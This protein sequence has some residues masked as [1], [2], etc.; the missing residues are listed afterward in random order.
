MITNFFLENKDLQIT[1]DEKLMQSALAIQ[2]FMS[3][4]PNDKELKNVQENID[5]LATLQY[6]FALHKNDSTPIHSPHTS[7]EFLVLNANGE[8]LL[9]SARPLPAPFINEPAGLSLANYQHKSW[10]IFTTIDPTSKIKIIVAEQYNFRNLLTG[11]ITQESVLIMLLSYPFLGLLI[12]LIVGRGLSSLKKISNEVQRRAP[13]HLEPINV[14]ETPVEIKAIVEEWNKLFIRLQEAFQREKRFAADAAHELKTPLAAL[15]AHTQVALNATTEVDRETA[16]R[17]ILAGVDRSAHVVQQLLTLSRVGQGLAL[18]EQPLPVNIV[19]QA[20]EVMAE[21]APEALQKNS[22]I[23]LIAPDSEPLITGHATA[24]AILIRNLV[25]NAIRYTPNGSFV[26][27]IIEDN[28]NTVVLKVIDNGP[29]IPEH[30][31]KQVFERFFR[32]LGNKSP[33]SG[34]GLGIVQQISELHKAKLTMET[35]EQGVGLQVNVIFP[36]AM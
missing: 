20:K 35:P 30:F 22:D 28:K 15:K 14:E 1:L 19:K 6:P 12:W 10:R 5:L 25:D 33:G 27:V 13:D 18:V 11:R 36:T 17:K 24:V 9:Q 23:E 7:F 26:R 21:L 4:S 3:Q 34:L 8:I 32:M 16:L 31:R 29:G 2:A